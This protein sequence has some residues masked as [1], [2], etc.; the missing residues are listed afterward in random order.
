MVDNKE[1]PN[2]LNRVLNDDLDDLCN[3]CRTP[4]DRDNGDIVEVF[5]TFKV[6]KVWYCGDCLELDIKV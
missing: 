2:N 4:Y 3:Q 5:T 1:L 6:Y